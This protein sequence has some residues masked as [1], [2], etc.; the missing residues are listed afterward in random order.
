MLPR[1]FSLSPEDA[2]VMIHVFLPPA[3]IT[4]GWV[5]PAAAE[6]TAANAVRSTCLQAAAADVKLPEARDAMVAAAA[7]A[8]LTRVEV[9]RAVDTGPTNPTA[10]CS[11]HARQTTAFSTP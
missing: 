8:W 2:P 4:I 10:A 5:A 6:R 7:L 1:E 9:P 11:R 3:A